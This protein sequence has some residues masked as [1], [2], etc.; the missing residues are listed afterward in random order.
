MLQTIILTDDEFCEDNE[1]TLCYS[2]LTFYVF[3][4][5]KTFLFILSI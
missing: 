3:C 4:A 1:G 5:R 2:L